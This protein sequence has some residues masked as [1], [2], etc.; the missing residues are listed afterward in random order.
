MTHEEKAF[1]LYEKFRPICANNKA[2]NEVA[3]ICVE[4]VIEELKDV[5]EI[6]C[7]S[8]VREEINQWNKVIEYLKIS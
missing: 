4:E 3:I 8:F 1:Q 2:A 6:T 7:S 5:L